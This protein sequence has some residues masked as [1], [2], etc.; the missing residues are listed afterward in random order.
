MKKQNRQPKLRSKLLTLALIMNVLFASS[1]AIILP[2]NSYAQSSQPSAT[3][4]SDEAFR[5]AV[6]EALEE[7]R[8]ARKLIEAQGQELKVKDELIALEKQLSA[9]LKDL[10]TLDAAE[11]KALSDALAAKDRVIAAYEAEI[12]VLKK[13][14]FTWW[15]AF[16][17]AAVGAGV[18]IVL[19]AVLI[20]K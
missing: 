3:P 13:N 7:L 17:T 15:K 14:K 5:R 8:A 4:V 19:G 12:V 18:G 9:G 6:A 20:N 1:V 16:K 10:R 2:A 11:R